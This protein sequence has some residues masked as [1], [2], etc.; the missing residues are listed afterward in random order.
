[1]RGHRGRWKIRI[2]EHIATPRDVKLCTERE[3]FDQRCNPVEFSL[4]AQLLEIDVVKGECVVAQVGEDVTK[5]VWGPVDQRNGWK[6]SQL[7][8]DHSVVTTQTR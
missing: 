2:E 8:G 1:M 6:S 5:Q 4:V 3:L 7:S